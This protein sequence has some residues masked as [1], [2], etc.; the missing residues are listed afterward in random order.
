MKMLVG[1]FV[2][3]ALC[4]L[5]LSCIDFGQNVGPCVAIYRDAALHIAGV[6]DAKTSAAI[7][8]TRISDFQ[9][10]GVKRPAHYFT[11]FATAYNLSAE[12][13]VLHCTVPC[14]F[15]EEASTYQFTISAPG[16]RDT[17]LLVYAQHARRESRNGGCPVIF[18]EGS[19]FRFQ[20]DPR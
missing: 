17:T 12:D 4:V 7:A 11:G 6:N 14:G 3:A 20:I 13:T 2:P 18:S 10:N 1:V 9:I 16:Y 15:G 5:E 19:R 8:K